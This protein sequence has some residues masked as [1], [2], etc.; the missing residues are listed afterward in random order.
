MKDAR[1]ARTSTM[2]QMLAC[3]RQPVA[4]RDRLP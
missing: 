3:E 1:I 4:M 2:R